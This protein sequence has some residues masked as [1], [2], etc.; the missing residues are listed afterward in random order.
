MPFCVTL[1]VQIFCLQVSLLLLV[2]LVLLILVAWKTYGG[3]LRDF[4]E[5]Y[6]SPLEFRAPHMRPLRR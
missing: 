6:G 4:Y 1:A 2:L 3:L 5:A